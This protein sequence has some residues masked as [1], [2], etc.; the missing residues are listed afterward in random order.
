M[1]LEEAITQLEN[2]LGCIE[3]DI[4]DGKVFECDVAYDTAE[5][6]RTAL[7]ALKKQV[8]KKP[9]ESITGGP[10]SCPVCKMPAR[11][12]LAREKKYCDNCGQKIDWSVTE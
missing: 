1:T 10:F 6:I 3:Y 8:G 7:P 4:C 2:E 9:I 12:V 11:T 5:A